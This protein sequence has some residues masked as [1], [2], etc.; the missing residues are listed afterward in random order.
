L[1][2]ADRRLRAQPGQRLLVRYIL[3]TRARVRATITGNGT[4]PIRSSVTVG[5]GRHALRLLVPKRQGRY[6]FTLTADSS[7]RQHASD[8][9]RLDVTR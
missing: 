4:R 7:P 1:T 3:T 8:R 9:L 2:L 6:V 5:P